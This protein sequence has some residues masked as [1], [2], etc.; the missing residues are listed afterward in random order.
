MDAG[1]NYTTGK[2][3]VI[4]NDGGLGKIFSNSAD[5]FVAHPQFCT[6]TMYPPKSK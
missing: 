5:V 4:I 6:A 1:A 3:P 2:R